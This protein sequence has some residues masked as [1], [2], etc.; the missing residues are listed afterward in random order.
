MVRFFVLLAVAVATLSLN[1]FSQE[2]IVDAAKSKLNWDASKVTGKHN[3]HI[4]IKDGMMKK[5]VSNFSGV[6][7]IDMN[8][9][10]IEDLKDAATNAKLL[11]H[12]RSD[13]FFSVDKFGTSTFKLK[14][15]KETKSKTDANITHTVTGDLTIKGITKEINFPATIKF[16]SNGFT[17]DAKFT[18][19]RAKWDI[20]YGSGSF[21]DNLGD[22]MIY[23]DIKFDL[24]LVGNTK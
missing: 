18:I 14:S 19:N 3:G 6:F 15:V 24:S 22:K 20:K 13:D 2:Y 7:N 8:T 12:L 5:E 21:F 23:D 11:G 9:I 17:A 4:N 1:V 16:T 10:K